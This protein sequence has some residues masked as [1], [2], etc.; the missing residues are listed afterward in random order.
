MKVLI[1]LLC[2]ILVAQGRDSSV[3]FDKVASLIKQ[4]ASG[5]RRAIVS[6]IDYPMHRPYPIPPIRSKNECLRRFDELFDQTFLAEIASSDLEGEDWQ[7]VG[8]RGII[9]KNG[10]LWLN[11]DYQISAI[12]YET[13]STKALLKSLISKQKQ[14]LPPSLRNFDEPD[15][16]WKTTKYIVRVDRKKD[17]YRLVI[18]EG[19]SR[20]KI[21]F[22]LH[23]GAFK[24]DGTMGA[25]FID[26]QADGKTHRVYA[27]GGT[28]GDDCCYRYDSLIDQSEWPTHPAIEQKRRN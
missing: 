3:E 26:W 19:H 8:W 13:R 14:G 25:Y 24:F 22:E 6:L 2:Q 9:F 16:E 11:D 23:N 4:I 1:F 28:G 12:N 20:A 5:D 27:A 15:L 21:L 7:R 18:F 17:D 10:S